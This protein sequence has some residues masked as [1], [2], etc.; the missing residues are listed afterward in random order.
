[1]RRRQALGLLLIFLFLLG[2]RQIRHRLLVGPDGVWRDPL[3]LDSLL[4][5]VAD[6]TAEEAPPPA[7]PFAVNTV[8]IDTLCYLPGIGPKLAARIVV[9]REQGGPFLDLVDLQR[10]KGIG[11]KLA[12]KLAPHLLFDTQ[13]HSAAADTSGEAM[14]PTSPES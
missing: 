3:W 8:G 11:P 1:M 9:A 2:G 12:A 13:L 6:A 14:G 7:G 10:V 5:A 4:P